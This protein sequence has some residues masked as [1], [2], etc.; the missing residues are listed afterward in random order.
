MDVNDLVVFLTIVKTKTISGAASA[1]FLAPSTVSA[2]LKALEDEI[3]FPV[4]SRGRG[5]KTVQLTDKGHAFVPY[6]EKWVELWQQSLLLKKAPESQHF[7]LCASSTLLHF[8]SEPFREFSRLHPNFHMEISVQDSDIAYLLVQQGKVDVGLIMYPSVVGNVIT[9]EIFSEKFVLAYSSNYEVSDRDYVSLYDFP[10]ENL[11]L[12]PPEGQ[13][14]DWFNKYI[15][16]YKNLYTKSNSALVLTELF[17]PEK[18]WTI[19]PASVAHFLK[20]KM[21]IQYKQIM[22]EPPPRSVYMITSR[23]GLENPLIHHFRTLLNE[24]I[25]KG[26]KSFDLFN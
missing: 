10:L 8:A 12:L 9:E 11:L 18:T 13:F 26:K 24:E 7:S 15:P 4:I 25:E 17:D 5:I 19:L 16:P 1:L 23:T 14:L 2:R 6:A 3:G 21:G 22:E 20:Q